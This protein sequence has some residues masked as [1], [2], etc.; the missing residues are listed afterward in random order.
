MSTIY[1]HQL[2]L[3][4]LCPL[5][6]FILEKVKSYREFLLININSVAGIQLSVLCKTPLSFHNNM[7]K[8]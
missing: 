7:G 8:G 5:P 1:H 4:L 3:Q 2:S 6:I